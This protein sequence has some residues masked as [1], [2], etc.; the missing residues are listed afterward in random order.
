MVYYAKVF[1]SCARNKQPNVQSGESRQLR[2]HDV[3]QLLCNGLIGQDTAG[4][5]PF[6][7]P[8]GPDCMA[9]CRPLQ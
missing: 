8:R 6:H 3:A 2:T 7:E 1:V 4:G 5:L 9:P